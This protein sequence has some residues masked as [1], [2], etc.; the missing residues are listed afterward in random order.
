MTRTAA[1]RL[2]RW[3]GAAAQKM[4]RL[5]GRNDLGNAESCPESLAV[6]VQRATVDRRRVHRVD[7]RRARGGGAQG[8][9]GLEQ[10]LPHC[11]CATHVW[12]VRP[13]AGAIAHGSFAHLRY[14]CR[15]VSGTRAVRNAVRWRRR[16][17]SDSY[18]RMALVVRAEVCRKG[19]SAHARMPGATATTRRPV[20]GYR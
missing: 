16:K 17:P 18:S 5:Q 1:V 3:G 15:T 14:C 19:L 20:P 13:A 2:Q 4:V 9:S 7:G 8:M 11:A 10:A 12:S 6:A